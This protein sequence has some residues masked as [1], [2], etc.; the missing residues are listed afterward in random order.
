MRI[1]TTRTHLSSERRQ[2]M[3]RKR[4]L[5]TIDAN[6]QNDDNDSEKGGTGDGEGKGIDCE[7]ECE[8]KMSFARSD[9]GGREVGRKS[10]NRFN[11]NIIV[12]RLTT[13]ISASY[14]ILDFFFLLMSC[15]NTHKMMEWWIQS[16]ANR[17]VLCRRWHTFTS[18]LVYHG[19]VQNFKIKIFPLLFTIHQS[20]VVVLNDVDL[21]EYGCFVAVCSHTFGFRSFFFFMNMA[22]K[23]NAE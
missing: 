16:I 2:A 10:E 23:K 18:P 13:Q 1:R 14:S 20:I 22:R 11:G 8:K 12:L 21:Y 17:T 7:P 3:S 19:F 4:E 9:E 5:N 6:A 15:T